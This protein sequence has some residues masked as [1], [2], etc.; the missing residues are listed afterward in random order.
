MRDHWNA[1]S[2]NLVGTKNCVRRQTSQHLARIHVATVEERHLL[3]C[4]RA[5]PQRV[6]TNHFLFFQSTLPVTVR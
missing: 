2:S 4:L 6:I 5:C 1:D 3:R